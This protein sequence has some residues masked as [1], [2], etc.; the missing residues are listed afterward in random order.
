MAP[1]KKQSAGLEK[2]RRVRMEKKA[3]KAARAA[4]A[5]KHS[6]EMWAKR[7]SNEDTQ[8][9]VAT[10]HIVTH[11]LHIAMSTNDDGNADAIARTVAAAAQVG[12]PSGRATD[13]LVQQMLLNAMKMGD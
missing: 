11:A 1:G 2:A 5:S 7:R 12:T 13:I 6:K 4:A 10:E 9:G 8:T 3:A